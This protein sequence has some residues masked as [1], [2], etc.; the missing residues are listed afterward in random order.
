MI[1]PL[2]FL[3][4]LSVGAALGMLVWLMLGS[5]DPA[6]GPALRNLQ[7]QLA[8][9]SPESGIAPSVSRAR[10]VNALS[11]PGTMARLER[12]HVLAGRP[13]AW[14]PE[15]SAMAKIVLAFG[16]ALLALVGVSL[17]PSIGQVPLAVAAV[18]LAY[19]VPELLLYSRGQERQE[20][21]ELA[22][23]DTLDQMTIAVEAGL[24]FEAAMVR[25]ARNGTGPLT[26]ELIRTL[27]DI[28]MGQTRRSAY[29]ELAARTRAPN[30]RRF[31][32]AVIQAD[33]YGVAIADVLRTQA[34]EM[35]L[36]RRQRAE[37]KAMQVPVKV[38]F[39]L[40]TCILPTVFVVILGPAVISMIQVF[41]NM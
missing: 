5:R 1:P 21:I 39:P 30:L 33:E 22:L 16:A 11:P 34:G 38:L 8:L 4:A 27:Q 17:T 28:Q 14:A 31:L 10:I 2:V 37:E 19:F 41:S 18:V 15:R 9:P 40:L 12:L 20:A 7:S 6:R 13:A 35:R 25:A 3:A 36:K 32:R 29:L 23:A 24:G 26:E